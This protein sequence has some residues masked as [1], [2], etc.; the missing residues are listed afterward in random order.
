MLPSKTS[1]KIQPLFERYLPQMPANEMKPCA[2]KGCP[3][4]ILSDSKFPMCEPCRVTGMRNKIAFA[5]DP[6]APQS[7]T[8]RRENLHGNE[9][10]LTLMR[11][12]E[13]ISF[14]TNAEYVYLE[15][16]K[17]IKRYGIGNEKKKAFKSLAEQVEETR[18]AADNDPNS[19]KANRL[20]KAVDRR[21]SAN[22]K[23]AKALNVDEATA[24]KWMNEDID[25]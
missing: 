2:T 19:K 22:Q 21:K 16:Q 12:D 18:F 4:E 25:L 7:L 6:N 3:N 14:V 13:M 15:F 5:L 17:V 9:G 23:A 20:R 24:E 1:Y 8:S 10:L 11:Q